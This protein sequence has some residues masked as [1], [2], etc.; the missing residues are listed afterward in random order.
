M[1][2]SDAL[3]ISKSHNTLF[4]SSHDLL[5]IVGLIR[6]FLF[7][8]WFIDR[9]VNLYAVQMF[10]AIEETK[11][12]GLDAGKHVYPPPQYSITDRSKA[13]LLLCYP[14]LCPCV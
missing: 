4:Q 14:L 11:G 9:L 3:G 13:V 12:A 1:V 6:D 10:R 8:W 7:L 2:L 5:Y